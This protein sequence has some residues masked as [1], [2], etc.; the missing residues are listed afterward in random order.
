[1]LLFSI[2][3][4]CRPPPSLDRTLLVN[5]Q[6]GAKSTSCSDSVDLYIYRLVISKL[7]LKL[8]QKI[9]VS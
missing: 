5:G 3:L 2:S 1:M 7:V 8:A 9:L 6:T 4:H